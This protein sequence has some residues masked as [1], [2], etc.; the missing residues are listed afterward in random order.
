MIDPEALLAE[1]DALEAAGEPVTKQLSISNRAHVLF[2][3]HRLMEKLSEERPGRV[4]IGTT[5]RGIGPCYEGQDRPPR[6]SRGR[7]ARSRILPRPVRLRDGREGH[8]RQ[9]AGHLCRDRPA[10]HPRAV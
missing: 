10:R 6:D 8:H 4:S 7:P 1:I 5:S 2:P 3:A 9:G